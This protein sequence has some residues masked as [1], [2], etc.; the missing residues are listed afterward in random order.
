MMMRNCLMMVIVVVITAALTLLLLLDALFQ[1]NFSV[2]FLFIGSCK[3]TSACVTT[4]WFLSS[5]CTNVCR[6]VI[7]S[8]EGS[9]ADATLERFLSGVDSDVTCEF[10]GSRETAVTVLNWTCVRALMNWRLAWPIWIF[11][12]LH[13]D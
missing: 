12:R 2:S 6:Q 7:R 9:H 13:W 5:V 8:R 11:A 3:F 10:I 4:E 1:M